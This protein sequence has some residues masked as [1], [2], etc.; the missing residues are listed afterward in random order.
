MDLSKVFN[1]ISHELLFAKSYT[2]GFSKDALKL[3]HRYMS[4]LWLR[5]KINKS[6]S[7]WSALTKGV[8][9]GPVL[10]PIFI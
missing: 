1:A 8:L 7:T 3:M 5:I 9:Q 2:C 10:G 6:F 4:D